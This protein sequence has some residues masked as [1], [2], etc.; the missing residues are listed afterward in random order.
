MKYFLES[1]CLRMAALCL[2]LRAAIEKI[3]L[4]FFLLVFTLP[5][6]GLPANLILSLDGNGGYATIASTSALQNASEITIEAWIYLPAPSRNGVFLNKGD[7]AN[8]SRERSYE[9]RWVTNGG[10]LGLPPPGVECS[11]FLDTSTWALV[12]VHASDSNWLHVAATYDSTAGLYRLFTNG[13]LAA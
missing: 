4:L 6:V 3:R 2:R 7:G 5:S 8:V 1:P 11:L 13:V 12:G 10:N 9:I